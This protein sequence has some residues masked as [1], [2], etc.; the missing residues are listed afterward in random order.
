MEEPENVTTEEVLSWGTGICSGY[1]PG[2]TPGVYME[3]WRYKGYCY[4]ITCGGPQSELHKLGVQWER[5][6]Q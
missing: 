5:D 4:A 6:R 1:V 3:I 2:T